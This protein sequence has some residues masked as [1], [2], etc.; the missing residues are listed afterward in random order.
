M[1][2]GKEYRRQHE[3]CG[4]NRG[5]NRG[6]NRSDNRR[7]NYGGCRSQNMTSCRNRMEMPEGPSCGC[8]NGCYVE[9]LTGFKLAMVYSPEQMWENIYDC[10]EALENGTLFA[11]LN[12]PWYASCCPSP[13]VNKSGCKG[14]CGDD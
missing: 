10:T 8:E 5:D 4:D 7:D 11:D 1:E 14:G 12:F 6:N 9:K 13:A 2:Y 3:C